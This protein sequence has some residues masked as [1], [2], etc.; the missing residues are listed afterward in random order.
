MDENF[1]IQGKYDLICEG[2]CIKSLKG[3]FIE[4]KKPESRPL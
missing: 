4:D 2:N 1:W 3:K